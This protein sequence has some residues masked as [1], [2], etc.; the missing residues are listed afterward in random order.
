MTRVHLLDSYYL[1]T[2]KVILKSPDSGEEE[3]EREQLSC[4]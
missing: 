2:G 4:G 1:I 3:E